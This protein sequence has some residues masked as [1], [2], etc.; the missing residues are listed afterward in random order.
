MYDPH[1]SAF[2]TMWSPLTSA[3]TVACTHGVSGDIG[4]G[5]I[6]DFDADG[7]SDMLFQRIHQN[8]SGFDFQIKPSVSG[9]CTGQP[10]GYQFA[11]S[12]RTLVFA[13]M[14]GSGDGKP[15]IWMLNPDTM[16]WQIARSE[17]SFGLFTTVQH[18]DAKDIPL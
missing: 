13:S 12:H 9:A 15:D 3:N 17:G 7:R 6:I 14:D 4:L 2:Y 11:G 5:S 8:G 1:S 18:G 10:I 16:T